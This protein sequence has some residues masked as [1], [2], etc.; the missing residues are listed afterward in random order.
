MGRGSAVRP[1]ISRAGCTRQF[2]TAIA[3]RVGMKLILCAAIAAACLTLSS[4]AAAAQPYPRRYYSD[5][6]V[7]LQVAPKA[8]EVYVDG[9][10]AGTVDD[11][12]GAFQRLRLESGG[13]ELMIWADG[14]RTVRLKILLQPNQTFTVRQNLQPLQPGDVQDARPTAPVAP[15]APRTLRL[16]DGTSGS[17]R[18]G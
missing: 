2:G 12:D 6:S 8:A 18:A 9:Y 10:Y 7:R 13:H 5:S 16:E 1:V 15:A 3:Q 4:V 17:R 14:F 11:Y